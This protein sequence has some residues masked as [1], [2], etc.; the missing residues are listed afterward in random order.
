MRSLAAGQAPAPV[1]AVQWSPQ[2][3]N[4][5]AGPLVL[6]HG[7]WT[8]AFDGKDSGGEFLRNGVYLFKLLSVQGT[9]NFSVDFQV[10]VIGGGGFMV[11]LLAAPN[12]L[13]PPADSVS[14]QWQ[15]RTQVVELKIYSLSG[16]LVRD[17]GQAVSP[18]AW[19][20]RS[21]SG[22]P[23]ADG[24]YW[25]SARVPGRRSPQFFKLMVAR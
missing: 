23:V 16:S 6:S 12:P 5:Q 25:I 8:F 13:R 21:A 20:L 15:P 3:Y 17:L 14:I 2:P 22:R 4:P 10:T 1:Q 7:S 19:D 18:A 24:V 11:S 9:S